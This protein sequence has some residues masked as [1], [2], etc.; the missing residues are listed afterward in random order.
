MK[1][2][3]FLVQRD[4]VEEVGGEKAARRHSIFAPPPLAV[5]GAVSNY[6]QMCNSVLS[7]HC[8]NCA[9]NSRKLTSRL[10]LGVRRL[11]DVRRNPV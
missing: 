4:V 3:S 6:G 5:P 9:K 2:Q 7:K 1:W 8:I 11:G 10:A